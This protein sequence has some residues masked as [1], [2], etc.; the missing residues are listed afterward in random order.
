MSHPPT[1]P[2]LTLRASDK[3][4]SRAQRCDALFQAF[5]GS[6]APGVTGAYAKDHLPYRGWLDESVDE[7]IEVLG[8]K[9]PVE[10]NPQDS[11][12]ILRCL[13]A[14]TPN[15]NG[16][17]SDWNI[18]GRL[19]GRTARTFRAFLDA[20]DAVQLVEYALVFPDGRIERYGPQGRTTLR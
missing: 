7:P 5:E 2:A 11:T 8:G 12:F 19:S 17:W 1:A 20:G 6:F 18:Y 13:A 4:L 15:V 9:L 3:T 14:P 16:P 10:L